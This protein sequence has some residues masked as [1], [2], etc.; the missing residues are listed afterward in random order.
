LDLEGLSG[1]GING[2]VGCYYGVL[3]VHRQVRGVLSHALAL[4]EHIELDHFLAVVEVQLYLVIFV[5]NQRS[6]S[7]NHGIQVERLLISRKICIIF[8]K[9]ETEIINLT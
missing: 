2:V 7:I 1:Y 3:D 9:I 5:R 6:P 4:Q 8:A